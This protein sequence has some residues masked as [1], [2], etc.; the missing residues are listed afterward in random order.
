MKAITEASF[1]QTVI[2]AFQAHGCKVAAIRRV[3]VQRKNGEVYY[4]TPMQGE[5]A[6]WPDLYIVNPEKHWHCVAELKIG[7]RPT[8]AEQKNWLR[9]HELSG[10]PA[11]VWRDDKESWDEIEKVLRD[12]PESA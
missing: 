12:G 2:Q 7:K 5:G 11:F 4:E 9:W 1:Q 6:G 8:T 10:T 3:R